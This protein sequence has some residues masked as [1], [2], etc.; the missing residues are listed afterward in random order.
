LRLANVPPGGV[1]ISAPGQKL[2]RVNGDAVAAGID[3]AALRPVAVGAPVVELVGQIKRKNKT[4]GRFGQFLAKPLEAPEYAEA[5]LKYLDA[6]LAEAEA[7]ARVI[8]RTPRVMDVSLE[9]RL[10]ASAGK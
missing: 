2:V 3:L 5:N 10:L 4:V 1:A 6:M 7:T 8:D 9:I